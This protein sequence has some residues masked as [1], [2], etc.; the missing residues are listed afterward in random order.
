MNDNHENGIGLTEF[1]YQLA[2]PNLQMIKA[3][4]PYMPIPQQRVISLMIRMQEM[5]RTIELFNGSELTAMGL[6]PNGNH[7]ASPAEMLQAMKPYA[8]PRE[9]DMIEMLENMQIMIQ[10]MQNQG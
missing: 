7:T 3:A 2:D 9:R 1:D 4:I 6:R 8:G 5:R 10:A